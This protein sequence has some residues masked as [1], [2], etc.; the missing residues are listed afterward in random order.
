MADGK[1]ISI[2]QN[3]NLIL[4]MNPF[5]NHPNDFEA[6]SNIIPVHFRSMY[7]VVSLM[8]PDLELILRAKCMQCGIKAPSIISCR[9]KTL[10]ELCKSSFMS[11]QS[12]YQLTISSFMSV[13]QTI[14]GK[15]RSDTASLDSRPTSFTANSNAASA[16][17]TKYG[18]TKVECNTFFVNSFQQF[19]L[20]YACILYFFEVL[21]TQTL[22]V[23]EVAK[24][25]RIALV[26][27]SRNEHALI[28]QALLDMI[29]PRLDSDVRDIL[30]IFLTK[31]LIILIFCIYN[32]DSKTFKKLVQEVLLFKKDPKLSFMNQNSNM[33]ALEK[34]VT[35]KATND[36]NLF[37]N[38]NWV[39]KCLQI[40]AVSTTFKG[41]FF[42]IKLL[43]IKAYQ[44]I[45]N[46]ITL[47][48]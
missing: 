45:I 46:A 21:T 1:E 5:V 16:S 3:F 34:F 18:S 37:P 8:E 41:F 22:P 11:L 44:L 32:Q 13:I 4:T 24:K 6:R 31:K 48:V 35:E 39:D 19:S 17:N 30:I 12:K 10:Y 25:S 28:G 9:L 47:K 40:Y 7:R 23:R 42:A 29:T 20:Y 33:V 43:L 27:Y 36:Y 26:N 2:N 15:G 14:Y 38:K